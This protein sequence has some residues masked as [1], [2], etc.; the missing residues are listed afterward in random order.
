MSDEPQSE[1]PKS[2]FPESPPLKDQAALSAPGADRPPPRW[3]N[4]D[5][6]SSAARA[7]GSH[8]LSAA[9][10]QGCLRCTH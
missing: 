10:D 8:S 7:I 1:L 3:L 9:L 6:G 4:P 5:P 2:E